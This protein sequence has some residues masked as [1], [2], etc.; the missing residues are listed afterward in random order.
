MPNPN[1]AITAISNGCETANPYQN[2]IKLNGSYPLP[3]DLLVAGVFQNLPGAPYTALHTVTTAQI[4]PSLGRP[5]SGGT[6]TVTVDLLPLYSSFRDQR[7][8]QFDFRLSKIF[9]VGRTRIQS[10]FD[11]FNVFNS[12]AALQVQ[13]QYGGTWLQPTQIIDARLLKLGVQLD[14]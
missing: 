6:R 14:F 1:T 4:Q 10:N 8:S 5:L 13:G 9:R 11:V 3:W 12:S 7:V 2:R